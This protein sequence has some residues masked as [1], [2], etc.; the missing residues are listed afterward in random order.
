MFNRDD[1]V[2]HRMHSPHHVN[3]W[4]RAR[5]RT[6]YISSDDPNDVLYVLA[7]GGFTTANDLMAYD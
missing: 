5:I 3:R 4:Y 1:E 2:W 7:Y 6:V